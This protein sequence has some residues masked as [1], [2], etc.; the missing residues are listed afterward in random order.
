MAKKSLKNSKHLVELIGAATLPAIALLSKV[1]KFAFLG[2]LDT[3]QPEDVAR[4]TLIDALSSVKPEVR[5]GVRSL[6]TSPAATPS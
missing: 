2:V 3:S 5:R 1:E 4:S 6:P